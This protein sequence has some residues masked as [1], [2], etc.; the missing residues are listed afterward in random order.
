MLESQILSAI[1]GT[2][3]SPGELEQTGA[4][5]F[6]L[7][8]AILMRE[9]WGGRQGDV[10]LDYLHS[11]PLKGVFYDSEAVAP[12]GRV[13]IVLDT[14]EAGGRRMVRIRI[15]DNG[16]GVPEKDRD[17]IFEPFFTTKPAGFGLGL[18]NA[19]KIVEQHNGSIAV[20]KLA[21]LVITDG[22]PSRRI[23]DIRRTW[24]VVKNGIMYQPAELYRAL[25][26]T[27]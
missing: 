11:E 17:N 6:N 21:D 19:R 23:S 10:I 20:G 24:L 8:R 3:T 25:G 1:L 14:V 12:G 22:D 27:P 9:G 2:P 15:S 26:V 4:R 5:I 13:T 18:A 7:Q 16:P